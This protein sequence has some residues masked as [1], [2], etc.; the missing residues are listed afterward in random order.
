MIAVNRNA[1]IVNSGNEINTIPQ[2]PSSAQIPGDSSCESSESDKR[3]ICQQCDDDTM[4]YSDH[5]IPRIGGPDV[6]RASMKGHHHLH[7]H[8]KRHPRN[9]RLGSVLSCK[10]V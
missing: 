6:S 1:M 9:R 4:D 7:H 8:A 2:S 10:L 5:E 3:H